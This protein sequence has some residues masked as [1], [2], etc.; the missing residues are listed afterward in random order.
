MCSTLTAQPEERLSK[1]SS[2]SVKEGEDGG[3]EEKRATAEGADAASIEPPPPPTVKEKETEQSDPGRKDRDEEE[4]RVKEAKQPENLQEEKPAAG[5][6]QDSGSDVQKQVTSLQETAQTPEKVESGPELE[7]TSDVCAEHESGAKTYFET[8][9]KSPKDESSGSYY[10]LSTATETKPETREEE[11]KAAGRISLEQRS[12]SLNIPAG[13]SAAKTT[14]KILCEKLGPIAGSFDESEVYPSTPSVSI[15]PTTTESSA[16]VSCSAE[17]PPPSEELSFEASGSLSE[18]L[19]LAGALPR[20]SLER[21]ELDHVR[22]KSM[23]SNVSAL[24]GTSLARL[25]LGE[26]SSGGEGQLEE[27]GYCVFSEYS[28]PMPSPADVPSPGDSPHQRFPSMESEVEEE[29]GAAEVEGVKKETQQQEPKETIPKP[30]FEKK[31]SPVKSSLILEKAVTSGVKPD[32]L[33]IPSSKDRLT[34]FRL[35]SRLPGDIKIQ[36]IPEVD[37]EKDPSR[38]ASPIPPDNSFTFTVA[39]TGNKVPA[40]PTTP[41]SPS[42]APA[43]TSKAEEAKEDVKQTELEEKTQKC[44]PEPDSA[45]SQRVEKKAGCKQETSKCLLG[46]KLSDETNTPVKLQEVTSPR[47]HTPSPV[48][49]IPQA[50][51]EEEADEEEEDVEM[52]EE[53]MEEAGEEQKEPVRLTVGDH[54]LD[55]DPKSGADEWS[56]SAQNSDDAEPATDSSHLSPCSGEEDAGKTEKDGEDGIKEQEEVK[57]KEGGPEVGGEKEE[58]DETTMDVSIL[59]TDS[60]WMDS[61]GTRASNN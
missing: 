54:T 59:D 47:P 1:A 3:R 10:E 4:S 51:V 33:R 27:L 37:V 6:N 42:D 40:T 32:R 55:D 46:L 16:D 9:S 45:S 12:L 57:A 52:A 39:E 2:E 48:I 60:G 44:E 21:R 11:K 41:K 15:T 19:D 31:D 61:Q 7:A 36:A 14:S 22:R 50:Q 38:E 13:S 58:E 49:I 24:V 25:A 20:A 17:A 23:P 8:S 30:A 28:G 29:P 26:Q 43:E 53:V 18:M 35:E 56:H 34:E 5:M